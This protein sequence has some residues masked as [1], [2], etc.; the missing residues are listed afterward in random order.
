MR[1]GQKT[2][3]HPQSTNAVQASCA[4]AA[5]QAVCFNG[6]SDSN[7][8]PSS[9]TGQLGTNPQY[10]ITT[11]LPSNRTGVPFVG[12]RR[13]ICHRQRLGRRIAASRQLFYVGRQLDLGQEQSQVKFGA[14]VRRDRFD[15]TLYY[16]VSGDFTFNSSTENQV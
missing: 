14:D 1:E 16:N 10:G 7:S 2:F 12:H 9:I 6:T 15:Q 8:D 3:Q 5:A 13:R 11:G 4:S